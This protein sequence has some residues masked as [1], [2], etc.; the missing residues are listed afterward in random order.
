MRKSNHTLTVITGSASDAPSA[1]AVKRRNFSDMEML[2]IRIDESFQ[3]F[4]EGKDRGTLWVFDEPSGLWKPD[5]RTKLRNIYGTVYAEMPCDEKGRKANYPKAMAELESYFLSLQTDKEQR[6]PEPPANLIPFQNGVFDITKNVMIPYTSDLYFTSKLPWKYRPEATCEWFMKL[7]SEWVPNPQELVDVLALCLYRGMPIQKFF[8]FLGCGA[9]GKTMLLQIFNRAL[10][11]E[12]VSSLSVSDF[13]ERF[14]TIE[15]HR[16][17]ANIVDELPPDA[18]RD[19]GTLK[20]LTGGSQISSDVKHRDRVQFTSYATLIV[21]MNQLPPTDDT[22][23][24]FYRRAYLLDFPFTIPVE[25]RDRGLSDKLAAEVENYEGLIALAVKSLQTAAGNGWHFEGLKNQTVEETRVEYS[26]KSDTVNYLFKEFCSVSTGERVPCSD[27]VMY[28][29][30]MRRAQGLPPVPPKFVRQRMQAEGC[31]ADRL[32]ING[33]YQL[34]WT[35]LHLDL[36]RLNAWY[37]SHEEAPEKLKPTQEVLDWIAVASSS[38]MAVLKCIYAGYT[39]PAKIQEIAKTPEMM[40]R[41]TIQ[42]LCAANLIS[43]NMISVQP[44]LDRVRRAMIDAA[45]KGV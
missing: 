17:L 1:P 32:R 3:W 7:F 31:D 45:L 12:N 26:T 6:L 18:I 25:L 10:G 24:A 16:K 27:L 37:E 5:G 36:E 43:G 29:N 34:C 13:H 41:G 33:E 15:L 35:D 38:E 21:A 9:N 19:S 23:D 42:N 39:S 44:T 8:F 14:A 30:R 11:E 40:M 22:S 20:R 2:A 28:V 4:W